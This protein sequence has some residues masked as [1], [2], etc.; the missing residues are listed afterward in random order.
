MKMTEAGVPAKS[1]AVSPPSKAAAPAPVVAPPSKATAPAPVVNTGMSNPQ[2]RQLWMEFISASE[3]EAGNDP[4]ETPDLDKIVQVALRINK[5]P[6]K[7]AGA[8]IEGVEQQALVTL[9]TTQRL[10]LQRGLENLEM[11]RA[12]EVETMKAQKIAS[13]HRRI[14]QETEQMA[15][16]NRQIMPPP[17]MFSS[18]GTNASSPDSPTKVTRYVEILGGGSSAKELADNLSKVRTL[19]IQAM[20]DAAHVSNLDFS[21]QPDSE[22][23]EILHKA[24]ELG[25]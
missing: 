13:A 25:R 15:T 7:A 5:S 3:Q 21:L 11:Q 14:Q 2:P 17:G 10:V 6:K 20:H 16:Q 22:V 24:I 8:K 4:P 9:S 1:K 18:P 23:Y 19:D 12:I